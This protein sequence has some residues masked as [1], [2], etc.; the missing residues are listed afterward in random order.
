MTPV[1]FADGEVLCVEAEVGREAFIIVTGT[2]TVTQGGRVIAELGPGEL[3]GERALLT[4]ERRSATV[5]ATGPVTAYVMNQ[6]EFSSVL[7]L[8]G[9][10]A[11]VDV[12]TQQRQP[13]PT[14]AA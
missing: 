10:R 1:Q 14:P 12:V 2:A 6:R 4:G 8:R 7:D 9:V 13:V 5:T 11:A 3:V